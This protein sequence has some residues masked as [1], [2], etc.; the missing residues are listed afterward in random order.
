M[1]ICIRIII[2][3]L[4]SNF[5]SA[6]SQ[7]LN[8]ELLAK[9]KVASEEY[10]TYEREHRRSLQTVNTKL[11]YLEW[12]DT[13]NKDKVLI[14]LHGS[15]SNAYEAKPFA[16]HLALKGYRVLAIDQYN[17]GRTP[18]PNFDASFDDLCIDIKAFMDSLNI[19][20]TVIGG[21]SR[22]GF[23]ATNFY[24][25]YPNS[26]KGIVLEDGGSVAF[27]C[28]YF[29][30][31]KTGL[32]NKLAEVNTPEEVKKQYLGYYKD[33]FHAYKSLYDLDLETSQFEILSYIKPD[34]DQW[35]TYRG[36]SEYY[37]MQ[38]S[39][40]MAE[41]LFNSPNVSKYASSIIKINP[42]KIFEN[43]DVPILL[44][45]AVSDTDP[46]PVTA[47]NK[48]LK[49]MHPLLINHII[50]KNVAHNIHYALPDEFS[51]V[52]GEFLNDKL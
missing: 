44:L 22:G 52:L 11:S 13:N 35:I 8:D 18:L 46:I 5:G 19:N 39:L 38:D 14:W 1:M 26:V 10:D 37:H 12:G 25:M 48:I 31:N 42:L 2:F 41:V 30:L 29:K 17:S 15:L 24:R 51:K 40:H 50:F 28:S 4:I 45:D 32:E 6:Y 21:F 27:N 23:L 47:E 36:M 49:A 20:K 43:L 7:V 16:E 9:F 34:D 3:L 33:K